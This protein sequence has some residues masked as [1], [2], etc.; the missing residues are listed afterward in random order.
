[1]YFVSIEIL[2]FILGMRIEWYCPGMIRKEMKKYGPVTAIMRV[3]E[4]FLTYKSGMI[5]KSFK[6]KINITNIFI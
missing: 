6:V 2:S 5:R 3:Y 4:D 1:L